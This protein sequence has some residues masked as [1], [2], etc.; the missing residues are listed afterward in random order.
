MA[1]GKRKHNW[2]RMEIP[3]SR[4]KLLAM[5]FKAHNI[6]LYDDTT[7]ITMVFGIERVQAAL[8]KNPL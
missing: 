4:V 5:V 2:K 6:S 8:P 1:A 7:H 3:M